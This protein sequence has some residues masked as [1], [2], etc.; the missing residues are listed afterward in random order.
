M[1][2]F[3]IT[4]SGDLVFSEVDNDSKRL[5]INFYKSNV[6]TL[7]VSFD[8]EAYDKLE[9]S[10]DSLT[11]TFDLL[12]I[13]NN[14]RAD[15]VQDD[16]YLMQQILMRLKTSLGELSLR[17]EIG[18]MI[19]TVIHKELTNKALHSKIEKI[20]SDAIKDLFSDYS[21]KAIPRV[22]KSNG[23]NQCIDIYIYKDGSLLLSHGLE[24]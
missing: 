3:L 9:A 1:T 4:P 6:K 2:D 16:A 5:A 17:Q 18:S 14:K 23:Y 13:K 8:M 24:W 7:K 22:E 11:I 12:E 19:E 20:V 15:L 10:K 21:V